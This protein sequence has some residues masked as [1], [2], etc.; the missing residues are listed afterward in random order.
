MIPLDWQRQ[1]TFIGIGRWPMQ[2]RFS[3]N[4]PKLFTWYPHIISINVIKCSDY[5]FLI[6]FSPLQALLFEKLRIITIKSTA[7]GKFWVEDTESQA[8]IPPR[9]FLLPVSLRRQGFLNGDFSVRN[10]I[11]ISWIEFYEAVN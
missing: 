4:L 11:G 1:Q 6:W 8:S 7:D 9:H 3:Y 10:T 5:L 2:R